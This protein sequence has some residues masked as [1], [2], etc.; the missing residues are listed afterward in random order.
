MDEFLR[1]CG[2]IVAVFYR[3]GKHVWKFSADFHNSRSSGFLSKCADNSQNIVNK[4]RVDLRLQSKHLRFQI[5]TMQIFV[6]SIDSFKRRIISKKTWW[7]CSSSADLE[8]K[9]MSRLLI[10]ITDREFFRFLSGIRMF[11][12]TVATVIRTKIIR[13]ANINATIAITFIIGWATELMGRM[14]ISFQLAPSIVE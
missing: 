2:K 7:I 6:F 1:Q 4:M 14:L 12:S 8:S 11:F 13:K 10:S 3:I 9:F 5:L